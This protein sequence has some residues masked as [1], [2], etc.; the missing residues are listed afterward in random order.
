VYEPKEELSGVCLVLSIDTASI[1]ML[2]GSKWRPFSGV[3]LA[4]FSLL[5]VKLEGKK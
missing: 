5:G 3:G 1:A 2:E 4:T